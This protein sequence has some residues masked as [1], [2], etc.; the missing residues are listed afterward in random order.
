MALIAP[1]R[2]HLKTMQNMFKL[3]TKRRKR[4]RETIHS[5]AACFKWNT[6]SGITTQNSNDLSQA[7]QTN[8]IHTLMACTQ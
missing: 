5:A 2:S 4:E 1:C 8:G 7:Q 3:G 6:S